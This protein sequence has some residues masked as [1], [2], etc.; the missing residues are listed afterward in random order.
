MLISWL[1]AHI[2]LTSGCHSMDSELCWYFHGSR[3]SGGCYWERMCQPCFSRKGLACGPCH[4]DVCVPPEWCCQD[5]PISQDRLRISHCASICALLVFNLNRLTISFLRTFEEHW[6]EWSWG[7][8]ALSFQSCV[9]CP[10]HMSAYV[11]TF[12]I[13]DACSRSYDMESIVHLFSHKSISIKF[14]SCHMWLASGNR[15]KSI[16]H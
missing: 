2:T 4:N 13:T 1:C 9:H 7:W 16:L 15:Y 8:C 5:M 14:R 6:D 3:G 12:C 10:R 11:K